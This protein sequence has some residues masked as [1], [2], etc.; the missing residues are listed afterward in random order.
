MY[1]VYYTKSY[2]R[3]FQIITFITR[4]TD[5]ILKVYD[6]EN[7]IVLILKLNVRIVLYDFYSFGE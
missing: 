5:S 6:S 7:C 3:N 4:H 2:N 1:Q